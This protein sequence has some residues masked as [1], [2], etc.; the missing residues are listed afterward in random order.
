MYAIRSYYVKNAFNEKFFNAETGNYGSESTYQTYQLIALMGDM[1]SSE[2][3]KQV[4]KTIVDDVKQRDYH[5]NT[6]IIRITSYNVCYTK[7][8]R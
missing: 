4:V 2:Y 5:L 6:G 1:V 8:L 3:K 7:L